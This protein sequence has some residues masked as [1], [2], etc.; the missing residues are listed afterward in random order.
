MFNDIIFN[1]KYAQSTEPVKLDFQ[2]PHI[3]D[4]AAAAGSTWD[5]HTQAVEPQAQ[6]APQAPATVAPPADEWAASA[7]STGGW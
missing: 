1:F 7:G 2:I 5:E 6:A 4:W 3:D